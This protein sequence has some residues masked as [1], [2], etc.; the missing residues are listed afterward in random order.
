MNAADLL[1]HLVAHGRGRRAPTREGTGGV[2][3]LRGFEVAVAVDPSERGMR[4]RWRERV[5]NRP[6]SYLLVADD[7]ERSGWLR[8]LGPASMEG[9]VRSVDAAAL[10]RTIGDLAG[11]ST[12]ESVR[13]LAEEI[14]RLGSEGLHM[15]GLLSKHTAEVRFR[16]NPAMWA[17]ATTVTAGLSPSD[18]W[19]AI[20]TKLGY[21]LEQRPT[22]GYLA[23]YDGRPV[24]VVHPKNSPRAFT[25]LDEQG[26]P[27]EGLLARDCRD[28]GAPYGLLAHDG[29][30]RLFHAGS[31]QEWLD[32]DTRLL[33]TERKPFLA[34]LSPSYLSG[35]GL[36]ELRA[37]ARR[38]GT[39]LRKR[40]DRTIRFEA[41]PAL[42][43]GLDEWIAA[44]DEDI[45]DDARREELER[46]ALT[47]MFRILF[48]LYAESSGFLPM[49]NAT[50]RKKSLTELVAEAAETAGKWSEASTAL[51]SQFVVLVRAMRH[52]NRAW[53]VPAYN[54]SLF[55]S[56]DFE[57]AEL[58]ERMELTDPHFARLLIAVGWDSSQRRGI[59]YSSL[60][61]GHLG[62]I[63]E[64]LLSLRL[65]VTDRPLR[66]DHGRDR[67][68]PDDDRPEVGVGDLLW[69]THEGGRKA[70]G[71]YYTP[72]ELVQ[73]L[74]RGAVE[75][76][77]KRHLEKVRNIGETDP[78]AAVRELF[79]FSVLDPACGSAHFLVYVVEAL[80]DMTV[81]FLAESPLP[82]IA[83][84]LD[85]LRAG[86]S[87]GAA[88]DDAALLRRLVLKR[89][90]FGVDVSPMGAEI[91][92]MSLWLA[93]FVPGLSLSYLD[94]NVVVGDS[95][96]GV[97]SP[98][99]VG[100]VGT[101]WYD[102]LL[103]ALNQAITAV[104]RLADID[105]RT[106][107]EV[108]ASKEADTQAWAATR[109]AQQLFDLWTAHGLG[110]STRTYIQTHALSVISGDLDDLGQH[111]VG[112][113]TDLGQE[114]RF[115]HWPLAFPRVFDPGTEK[116][117][118]DVVVGNPPW[119]EVT[120]EQLSFY[121]MYKPGVNALPSA[122]RARAIADLTTARPDLIG[123]LDKERQRV[124]IH[125]KALAAGGYDSMAGDPDLYKYFCQRYRKL[126]RGDGSIGVVL[127][128][129]TFVNYGSRG[130]RKW[131]FEET[132]IR[133][134]DFLLNRK[135]WMF[136]TH[137]QYSVALVVTEQRQPMED[138]HVEIAGVAASR[139]E[140]AEQ[141]RSDGIRIPY[142]GFGPR[143]MTPLVGTQ[144]E[145]DVL[146]KVRTGCFFPFGERERATHRFGVTDLHETNDAHLW[147]DVSDQ[148][149]GRD[150]GSPP[151]DNA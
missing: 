12:L 92:L 120:V 84:D 47:L 114:H 83:S 89:C 98:E 141:S 22:R 145:A 16:E 17:D 130:F 101:I 129:S 50:Y 140:W 112:T 3:T 119:E 108:E 105:D 115:L 116:P 80:A 97:V 107:D 142:A 113:A 55:A 106:P 41:F 46:A 52:G 40:L 28:A 38:F 64:A 128:R 5:G 15:E 96:L 20:L 121:S 104:A 79:S 68:V 134:V 100:N 67:Y 123:R 76:A 48:I 39:A 30:F 133:R 10:A 36:A 91:A 94:R 86:T 75:P 42:A 110:P 138:H 118:F 85:R 21:K 103:D 149:A 26:R 27:S 126:T 34:L 6:V 54:G 11:M 127:P 70:G 66:Y 148:G 31:T 109:H 81:R 58:L 45:G 93:S 150:T 117:G 2:V 24:A 43:A 37:E 35:D 99:V 137:P 18:G 7:P 135:R 4:A 111:L 151:V 1:S 143:W 13:H 77:F 25:R 8:V 88:V 23:R 51:W 87:A 57:G 147:T 69:Q 78:G 49:N 71:V 56:T 29:R 65:S 82:D 72:P 32:I 61:I 132:T 73:H 74:V 62:H 144:A 124:A 19:R 63:Y 125:R 59:D 122:S 14:T 53:D 44:S 136:D 139:G 131:L 60:E 102:H 9:P 90:V 33:G 95:L 146:A